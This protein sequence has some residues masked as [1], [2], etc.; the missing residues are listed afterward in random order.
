M[1]L[2][3]LKGNAPQFI[4]SSQIVWQ[5][6]LSSHFTGFIFAQIVKCIFVT[7]TK[8]LP[9]CLQIG[10]QS[11]IDSYFKCKR[12]TVSEIKCE[13]YWVIEINKTDSVHNWNAKIMHQ[14]D[15][16]DS[17]ENTWREMSKINNQFKSKKPANWRKPLQ[18]A[19]LFRRKT[20]VFFL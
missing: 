17:K 1:I 14:N 6:S 12:K 5:M 19:I 9:F 8:L 18:N 13:F 3:N 20:P 16:I 11:K 7:Q 15:C 10:M 2:K 4:Q